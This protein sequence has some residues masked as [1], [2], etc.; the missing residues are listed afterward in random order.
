MLLWD[1]KLII[2]LRLSLERKLKKPVTLAFSREGDWV[3]GGQ[4]WKGDFILFMFL[5]PLKFELCD[6]IN[7]IIKIYPKSQWL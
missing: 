7:Y 2:L 6:I 4:K 1:F 5:Y 3:F